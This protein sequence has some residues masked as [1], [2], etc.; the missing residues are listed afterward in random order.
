MIE[1]LSDLLKGDTAIAGQMVKCKAFWDKFFA[2]NGELEP[3]ELAVALEMAQGD[4]EYVFHPDRGRL[5]RLMVLTAIGSLE[6][7]DPGLS[8]THDLAVRTLRA[9]S[10]SMCS[11]EIKNA[12]VRRAATAYGLTE[13]V[14]IKP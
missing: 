10:A 11:V 6:A 12:G 14:G 4:L 8:E 3:S 7:D 13:Q 2:D 5:K 1:L 9:F